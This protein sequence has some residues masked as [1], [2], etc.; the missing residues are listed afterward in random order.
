MPNI[1]GLI[2]QMI[3][4]PQEQPWL[5][6]KENN[7]DPQMIGEDISALANAAAYCDRSHAYLIWG[8][9]DNDHAIVGTSFDPAQKKTG[10]QPLDI[11]LRTQLSEHAEYEFNTA[12]INNQTLVVLIITRAVERTVMFRKTEYTAL[13]AAQRS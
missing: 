3:A 1:E 12:V 10:N 4:I 8:V 5:E 9:R 2:R 7:S 6:F 11:W 13:G